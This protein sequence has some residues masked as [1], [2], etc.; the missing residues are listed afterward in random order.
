LV[1]AVEPQT[2]Q[3]L[4][5]SARE[6]LDALAAHDFALVWDH[7]DSVGKQFISRRDYVRKASLCPG[8][9]AG[10]PI[11]VVSVQLQGSSRGIVQVRRLGHLLR[12]VA[13]YQAGQWGFPLTETARRNL[14]R[15]ESAIRR[16]CAS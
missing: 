1:S 3:G 8:P 12:F 16:S 9:F 2:E 15:S 5:A 6:A 13:H 4:L 7:L 11:E 10:A 14:S